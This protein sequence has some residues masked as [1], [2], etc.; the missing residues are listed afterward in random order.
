MQTAKYE[1]YFYTTTLPSPEPI[2]IQAP[3]NESFGLQFLSMSC[4]GQQP[5]MRQQEDKQWKIKVVDASKNIYT[6]QSQDNRYLT[7]SVPG[8][9]PGMKQMDEAGVDEQWVITPK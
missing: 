9:A 5:C 3:P 1:W 4:G 6:I 7:T 2:S 8:D